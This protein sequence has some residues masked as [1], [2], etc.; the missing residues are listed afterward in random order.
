MLV[1]AYRLTDKLGIV[2]LKSSAALTDHTLTGVSIIT[3]AGRGSLSSIFGTLFLLI[4]GIG[5]LIFAVLRRFAL[6]ILGIVGFFGSL[7]R[8]FILLFAGVA[9]R[10][11]SRVVHSAGSSAADIMARRAARAEMEVGLAEDPLRVQNRTLSLFIVGLL[12][13]MVVIALWATSP[14]RNPSDV[15]VNDGGGIGFLASGSTPVATTPPLMSTPVPTA[16]TLPSVLE[17]RGSVAY[18][19]RENGQDDIWGVNIGSHT[20]IR[21]VASPADDRDPAWSPDG[22]KLAYASH[23][24]GNWEIY[25]YN[26]L[27]N[28]T[29]RMTYNLSYQGAPQ[30]SPDN[31]H[32]LVYENYQDDNL[33]IYVVPVDGSQLPQRITDNPAPDFSPSWSPDGRR[34]AFVSWR[35]GNQDIYIFSLDNPVDAASINLTNTPTRQ[36][37]H[38]VWSPDGKYIAYSAVD[39]GIEKVFVKSAD[40]PQAEAQVIERGREPTWAPNGGASLLF[41]VDSLEGTQLVAAPSPLATGGVSTLAIGTSQYASSPSW[42]NVPLPPALVNAGGLPP[43]VAQPLYVEQV[44]NPDENG[45]YGLGS[46][47]NVQVARSKA[48]LSDKVNDSFNALRRATL[49]AAGWDFLG[50]LDD[51]FWGLD[52]LPQAGE[53]RRN[54]YMTGRAFGISRNLIA[55]FPAQIELTREDLDVNV[56]WRVFVR[57][58]EEAQN[59]ELGEPLRRM[60]WDMLSRNGDVQAY[61]QGGRLKAQVPAGYYVDFTQLALDYGWQRVPASSDWRANVNTINYWL[62]EKTGG[63][64]WYT[65][66]RELYTDAQMGGFAPTPTPG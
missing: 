3:K 27:T 58:A 31:G 65:A 46:L 60:P 17:A 6:I 21:L 38:P 57:V 40:D 22:T 43:G 11:S 61:D 9:Q 20:P 62:F 42:T 19:V 25:I 13:V 66:M 12:G 44:A 48:Y 15:P 29:T 63:L 41:A 54:W 47:Q 51:A 52:Q 14:A 35:D 34:I 16:T 18:V 8:R 10:S 59:G 32:W 39:A 2:L 33:D 23:K 26:L 56:Y 45:L 49:D 5:R 24:D 28:T 7:F 64:D 37:D 1:R 50:Q 36:E 4:L 53:E 55:G 30:W